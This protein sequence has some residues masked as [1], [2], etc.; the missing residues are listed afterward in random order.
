MSA[1]DPHRE[2]VEYLAARPDLAET[3]LADHAD[4]GTGRCR[5]CTNGAQAARQRHPCRLYEL[6]EK[7]LAE[8]GSR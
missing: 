4:D 5:V 3:L 8:S 2:L 7:A 6:A 1:E